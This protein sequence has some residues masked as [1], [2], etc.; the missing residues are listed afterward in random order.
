[1]NTI[2]FIIL[3]LT[4]TCIS[5]ISSA[6]QTDSLTYVSTPNVSLF[7]GGSLV[8]DCLSLEASSAYDEL[9]VEQKSEAVES[10]LDSTGA[11]RAV[12]S[13]KNGSVL[14]YK[15]DS[16]LA[17]VELG[18]NKYNPKEYKY[19]ELERLGSRKW[20]LTFGGQMI[21]GSETYTLGINARTGAF[22]FKDIIDLGLGA[23]F[24]GQFLSD[25]Y[26]DDDVH[27]MLSLDL[28]SRLYLSKWLPRMRI[29]P[30]GGFGLGY[31]KDVGNSDDDGSF[32][33]VF[34]LGANWYL[35]K[36][37]I[38]LNLQYG[39]TRDFSFNIGYTITF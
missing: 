16:R 5:S 28:S 1:M 31:S 22:L 4:A 29:T 33:P 3:L 8:D 15:K 36:G 12:V 11:A 38:D 37:A 26:E 6:Q 14:W 18:S 35:T 39:T 7:S 25:S 10:M 24:S 34:T 23:N 30:Y 32:E 21:F 20:F 17:F 13:S 19:L 27:G 2:R 9:S